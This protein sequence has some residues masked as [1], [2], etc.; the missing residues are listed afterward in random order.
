MPY[1]LIHT[2]PAGNQGENNMSLQKGEKGIYSLT[3]KTSLMAW[4]MV[5]LLA[6]T[7]G[8]GLADAGPGDFFVDCQ[9]MSMTSTTSLPVSYTWL[10]TASGEGD[11]QV[12]VDTTLDIMTRTMPA[13]MSS[14]YVT[15]TFNRAYG[16]KTLI[17]VTDNQGQ[18]GHATSYDHISDD[19]SSWTPPT[20]LLS[21]TSALSG[22]A[23]VTV[24]YGFMAG[25]PGHDGN[26]NSNMY[27]DYNGDRELTYGG[28][29][30]ESTYSMTSAHTYTQSGIYPAT[31]I[32]MD[33]GLGTGRDIQFIQVNPVLAWTI[34][35][36]SGRRPLAVEMNGEASFS[37]SGS[38]YVDPGDGTQ[39]TVMT[40][41]PADEA[42]LVTVT[43]SYTRAGTYQWLVTAVDGITETASA[44]YSRTV[45]VSNQGLPQGALMPLLGE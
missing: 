15:C 32:V 17:R 33:S 30:T 40:G 9:G 28:F 1:L 31:A 5:I 36:Q 24:N 38:L 25:V 26:T 3:L 23:P 41:L 12:T 19:S 29:M 11:R 39:P 16:G 14:M 35:P 43:H 6:T 21:V 8:N 27:W 34:S 10:V 44:V 42:V 2:G 18:V 22:K 7:A 4:L 20:T 13:G 37:D 45:D